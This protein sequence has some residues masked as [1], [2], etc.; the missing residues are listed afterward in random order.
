MVPLA[1]A[2]AT[3]AFHVLNGVLIGCLA[4]TARSYFGGARC[5]RHWIGFI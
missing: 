3:A 1:A 4:I 2:I 5:E